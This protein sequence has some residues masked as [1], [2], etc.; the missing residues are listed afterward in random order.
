VEVHVTE[1]KAQL[2]HRHPSNETMSHVS[3]PENDQI[4]GNICRVCIGMFFHSVSR[5]ANLVLRCSIVLLNTCEIVALYSMVT[6]IMGSPG[7]LLAQLCFTR[8]GLHAF[9]VVILK[10]WGKKMHA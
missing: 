10:F 4:V 8:I 1:C 9:Q 2:F 5:I 6:S 7:M 3:S